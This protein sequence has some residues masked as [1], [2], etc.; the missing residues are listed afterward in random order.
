SAKKSVSEIESFGGGTAGGGLIG[1]LFGF[2]LGLAALHRFNA[3]VDQLIDKVRKLRE[4][5]DATGFS[6]DII[7]QF[8]NL[9]Q[10][11]AVRGAIERLASLQQ[12]F[13]E[14]G[15]LSIAKQFSALGVA[16]DD[17]RSKNAH[18]LFMQIGNGLKGVAMSGERLAALKTV[19]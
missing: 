13:K 11:D 19:F 16:I 4:M 5:S 6:S 17:I 2:G 10:T 7:Q 9:G 14:S 1:R 12:K 3:G 18:Q 8:E 15:D